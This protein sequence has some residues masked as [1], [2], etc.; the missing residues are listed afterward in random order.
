MQSMTR[1]LLQS[2]S[3]EMRRLVEE[4]GMEGEASKATGEAAKTI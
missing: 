2:G 4:E 3:S 1:L